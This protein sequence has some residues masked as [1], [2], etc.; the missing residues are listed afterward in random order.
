MSQTVRKR[1]SKAQ[2]MIL[3][4]NAPKSTVLPQFVRQKKCKK[5]VP[6]QLTTL[7]ILPTFRRES[8]KRGQK[9]TFLSKA[10]RRLSAMPMSPNKMYPLNSSHIKIHSKDNLSS[11][12]FQFTSP[13][14][15]KS[16]LFLSKEWKETN[17]AVEA[18]LKFGFHMGSQAINLL[19]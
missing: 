17:P 11:A 8:L 18:R 6:S 14:N 13:D 5:Q 9:N 15:P 7:L 19:R 2:P 10:A 4:S 12:M 3:L 16:S 1:G